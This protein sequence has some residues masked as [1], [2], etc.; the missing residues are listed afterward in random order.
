MKRPYTVEQYKECIAEFKKAIPEITIAT[1]IIVGFPGETDADFEQTLALIKETK[2]DV[3]NISRFSPRPNTLAYGMKPVS[4]NTSKLRSKKVTEVVRKIV[5]EQNK[6]WL[7]WKGKVVVNA[8]GKNNA[9]LA[10]NYAY[11]QVVL[12]AKH[13]LGDEVDVEIKKTGQYDLKAD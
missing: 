10:R 8:T 5:R 4:T 6:K 2:P 7:G 11:K 13:Q 3:V 9:P 12:E 1:D